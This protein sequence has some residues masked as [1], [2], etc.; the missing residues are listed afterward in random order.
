MEE[1]SF[2]RY[3][4]G[5]KEIFMQ[6]RE[7]VQ[8]LAEKA[9]IR[10]NGNRPW[11]IQ[12][13]ND[14]LYARVL[15]QGTLGLGEAYMDGW[16]DCEAMDAMFCRALRARI[17][18]AFTRNMPFR[19]TEAAQAVFNLQS[20][21]RAFMVARAHYDTDPALFRTMLGPTMQYSCARWEGVD[22]V[23]GAGLDAAQEQKMEMI[24]RKLALE[25]G[26]TVLD[27]GCGWGTLALHMAEEHG[28]Q[29][30][31]I[32]VSREQLAFAQ[33]KAASSG[34][35]VE[36]RL[37][38]YRSLRGEWDRVVSVGMFEHV[39]RRNY[40]EFM[41]IARNCLK[42]GGLFL[43]HSIGSNGAYGVGAG[44]DP[45]LTHYIFPN[46]VLPSPATLVDAL[47]RDFI[48]EDWQNFGVDYDKTLM[49]WYENF[50]QGLRDGAFS[51]TERQHRMYQYY[52][53]SCAGA[54]RARS[55]QLWQLV[56][57]PE[58]MPGGYCRSTQG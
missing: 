43:L 50:E 42:S 2:S 8:R 4:A 26:M 37:M 14:E 24:C 57:S 53:L 47:E 16:W 11:D 12:V 34:A 1:A 22:A 29:V 18:Q 21:A 45:W 44:A 58:G 55:I 40:R 41:D 31:G 46:G 17:E 19:L 52:L 35:D 36:Y 3:S 23:G 39:G 15:R 27:I 9:D 49:A 25:P 32:T 54:F 28:V 33:D 13:H 48:L 5:K 30:T 38:D 10:I 20:R 51:C 7:I 56:L 6:A